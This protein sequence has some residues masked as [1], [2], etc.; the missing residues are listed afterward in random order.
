M[1]PS[2]DDWFTRDALAKS[3]RELLCEVGR[4]Y[5]PFMLA[6]ARALAKGSDRVECTIDGRVWTQRPFPYQGKCLGWLRRD[7]ATLDS[8]ARAAVDA[9]LCGT[10]CE[11]LFAQ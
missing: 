2:D 5:A 6:N 11:T 7:Y 10:G 8:P 9:A 3:L 4:V 1:E